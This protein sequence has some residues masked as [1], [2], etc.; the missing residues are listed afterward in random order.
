MALSSHG[1]Y[2]EPKEAGAGP[3]SHFIHYRHV[4]EPEMASLV[5]HLLD[6]LQRQRTGTVFLD[7]STV[8]SLSAGALGRLVSLHT[9]LRDQGR[10]LVLL[11]LTAQLVE[12]LEITR[13]HKL[14]N[15]HWPE[16]WEASAGPMS[17]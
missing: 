16:P 10:R 2:L 13:L 9:K 11:N 15:I 7:F 5:E 12:I 17:A 6:A 4:R 1:S 8:E 3:A 14:F